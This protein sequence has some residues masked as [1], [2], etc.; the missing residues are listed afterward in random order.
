MVGFAGIKLDYMTSRNKNYDY[1]DEVYDSGWNR[2]Y[3]E[4]DEDYEERMEDWNSLLENNN[5]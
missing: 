3:N 2:R 1:D 5:D 4:S